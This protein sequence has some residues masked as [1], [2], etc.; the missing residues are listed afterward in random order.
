MIS[1]LRFKKI[2]DGRVVALIVVVVVVVVVVVRV[3]HYFSHYPSRVRDIYIRWKKCLDIHGTD[4]IYKSPSSPPPYPKCRFFNKKP[5][6]L[7]VTLHLELI[8]VPTHVLL[9]ISNLYEN[10]H[11]VLLC[12][13]NLY[14]NVHKVLCIY[15]LLCDYSILHRFMLLVMEIVHVS[16]L[17]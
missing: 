9:C 15:N 8:W 17:G 1:I 3:G 7:C 16:V 4:Y 2:Q 6:V 14:E 12:I 13:Y 11:K 10:L 5:W